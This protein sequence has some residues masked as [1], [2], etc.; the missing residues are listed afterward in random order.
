MMRSVAVLHVLD[1]LYWITSNMEYQLCLWMTAVHFVNQFWHNTYKL[2]RVYLR[3]LCCC[4]CAV[5]RLSAFHTDRSRLRLLPVSRLCEVVPCVAYVRWILCIMHVALKIL[6][7]ANA[8]VACVITEAA[9]RY[10]VVVVEFCV[11]L[12][13][14]PL[15]YYK[16]RQRSF[17]RYLV[18]VFQLISHVRH[19]SRLEF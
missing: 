4:V 2:R 17:V 10:V 5:S 14:L 13:H 9:V 7:K 8:C 19:C 1:Y 6:S 18:I 16:S 11:Y 3:I 12:I 15:W